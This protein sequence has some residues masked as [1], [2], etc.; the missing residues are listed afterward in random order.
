MRTFKLSSP[1]VFDNDC[2][3]SFL[4]V[5]RPDLLIQVFKD[6]IVIPDPV[7]NELSNLKNTKYNWILEILNQ[8]IATDSYKT[9]QI[10][11]VG[12]IANEYYNLISDMLKKPMGSGEAAALSYV[13]Y[14]G[15]TVASNN[16]KD[17]AVY[18]RTYGIELIS[19]DDILCFAKMK[20]FI[21]IS[22]GE[23][24]WKE[25]KSRQRKLPSY[26]FAEALRRFE[27]GLQK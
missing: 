23:L 3:S 16:L 7:I 11:A 25:M 5:K 13:R 12:D 6:K 8:Q 2:L 21:T 24:L 27:Q 1:I 18:C 9:F 17:V 4:W 14:L 20:G 22:D 26:D 19:T 10:P 15:G